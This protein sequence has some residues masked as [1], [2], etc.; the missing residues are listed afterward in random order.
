MRALLLLVFATVVFGQDLIL[1]GVGV[2]TIT[3]DSTEASL[4]QQ[5]GKDAVVADIEEGEGSTSHGLLLFPKDPSRRLAI[6]WKKQQPAHPSDIYIC[7]L[8]PQD[9]P[10]RWHTAGGSTLGTTLSKIVALNGREIRL[11]TWGSDIGGATMSMQG[12]KLDK[13]FKAK[14]GSLWFWFGPDRNAKL[15][16][17]D[18]AVIYQREQEVSSAIPAMRRAAPRITRMGMSFD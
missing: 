10:C 6:V 7:Y 17:W 11:L 12:G 9:Q 15:S 16:P 18:E 5:F 13:W 2:G 3:K 4:R 1:P 14:T 8:A